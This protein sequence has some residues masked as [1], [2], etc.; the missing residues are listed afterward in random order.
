VLEYAG[1]RLDLLRAIDDLPPGYRVIF[2]LHD[3]EG[4]EHGEVAEI[5]GCTVGNCKSQLHKA[6]IKLRK[7]LRGKAHFVVE[8]QTQEAA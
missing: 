8:L 3:V 2:L 5:L 1:E 7:I 4:Y 6:R